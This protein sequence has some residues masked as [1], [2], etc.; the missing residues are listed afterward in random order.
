MVITFVII[1]IL[2]LFLI[3]TFILG[4]DKVKP[5]RLQDVT[6]KTTFTVIIPF[7]NEAENLPQLLTSLLKL[8]YPERLFEVILVDDDSED[9]SVEIIKR[10]LSKNKTNTVDIKII[11]N[12]RHTISPKKDA[13]TTAIK[14]AKNQW[15]ITTD[16]DC[17]VP[18]YWLDTF[19][20]CIETTKSEMI[21]GPVDY[22]E[23]SSLLNAFQTLD[24]LS[25]M[26]AT[27]SAFGINKP[28][29]CNGANLAYK[30]DLFTTLKGFEGNTNIASGDDIFLMEK[31]LKHDKKAVTYL[32]SEH[33]IVITKPQKTLKT[34]LS[35]R[36]RWASKTSNYNNTFA[37]LVGVLVLVANASI[38]IGFVLVIFKLFALK[39]FAYL[40]FIKIAVDFL[41][42]YKTSQFFDKE[43]TLK[44][45]T[46]SCF[47]Y[48]FFSVYVA[49]ISMFSMYKWKGRSFKK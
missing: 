14:Q 23:N 42:L 20:N 19:D 40:F 9:D 44:H 16:A 2:Y 27:I 15:I 13:I 7:R 21:A 12:Q 47:I 29:L 11:T 35:Q 43:S 33:A 41:L 46:W 8:N 48:P 28:F 34:L 45:Y 49:F 24:F 32:K 26:G 1:I 31:A 5:F 30:K 22:E 18:N 6:P 17:V 36:I 38:V 3:G 25:L 39:P 4:F 10:L 37:K